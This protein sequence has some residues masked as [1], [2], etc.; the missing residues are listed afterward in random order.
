MNSPKSKYRAVID[1]AYKEI[2]EVQA[3]AAHKPPTARRHAAKRF[4]PPPPP[5]TAFRDTSMS[6]ARPRAD[7]PESAFPKLS[8][9]SSYPT[10]GRTSGQYNLRRQTEESLSP[11]TILLGP[12]YQSSAESRPSTA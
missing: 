5:R 4:L 6:S 8:R 10:H 3:T 2:T 7:Q 9:R 11:S 1:R 12:C